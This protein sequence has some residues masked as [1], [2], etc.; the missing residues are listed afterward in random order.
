MSI[1]EAITIEQLLL[2]RR[3]RTKQHLTVVTRSPTLLYSFR[4][5]LFFFLYLSFILSQHFKHYFYS[6]T[7]LNNSHTITRQTIYQS[8]LHTHIHFLRRCYPNQNNLNNHPLHFLLLFYLLMEFL[9]SSSLLFSFSIINS[10]ISL[11]ITPPP[12]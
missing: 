10:A 6:H 11:P 4:F 7:F 1:H 9:T 12:T 8:N 2:F 5:H 3:L